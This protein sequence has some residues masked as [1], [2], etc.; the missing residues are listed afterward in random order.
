MPNDTR[1][2]MMQVTQRLDHIVPDQMLPD[3]VNERASRQLEELS[4]LLIEHVPDPTLSPDERL[5]RIARVNQER[6]PQREHLLPAVEK[7]YRLER[8]L[9]DLVDNPRLS[10][11]EKLE[12]LIENVNE[13]GERFDDDPDFVEILERMGDERTGLEPVRE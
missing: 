5:E 9:D 11:V 4:G 13:V 8:R 2:R 7:L 10:S 3:D 1:D 12:V 6:V